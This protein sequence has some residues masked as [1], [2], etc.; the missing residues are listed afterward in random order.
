MVPLTSQSLSF[1]LFLSERECKA[2]APNLNLQTNREKYF[3]ALNKTP[4]TLTFQAISSPHLNAQ[5]PLLVLASTSLGVQ[6]YV[7]GAYLPNILKEKY[8]LFFIGLIMRWLNKFT[9][10][11]LA[12]RHLKTNHL[13]YFG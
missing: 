3:L 13:H 1:S 2:K 11:Q 8:Q 6:R 9:R 10:N 7:G 5:T 4:Q 12:M